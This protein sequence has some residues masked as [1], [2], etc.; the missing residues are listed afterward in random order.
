VSPV[1][2]PNAPGGDAGNDQAE[3]GPGIEPAVKQPQL[4]RARRE[5]EEAER[6]AETTTAGV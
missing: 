3:A 5:L 1:W 4:G 6:G 2:E